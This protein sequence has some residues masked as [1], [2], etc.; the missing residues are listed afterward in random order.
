MM[1]RPALF[2]AALIVLVTIPRAV[3]TRDGDTLTSLPAGAGETLVIV[4][5]DGGT[6]CARA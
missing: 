4:R 3:V 2:V 1:T 6:P 5:L